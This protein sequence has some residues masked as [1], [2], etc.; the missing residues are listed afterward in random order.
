MVDIDD[1]AAFDN[2]A[3]LPMGWGPPGVPIPAGLG[4]N[5]QTSSSRSPRDKTK[6]DSRTAAEQWA[7]VAMFYLIEQMHRW[8][9]FVFKYDHHFP[10]V[11][12]LKAISGERISIVHGFCISTSDNF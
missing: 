2:F 9:R 8:K 11:A 12:A 4:N 6:K 3:P 5:A 1:D 10:S 7:H